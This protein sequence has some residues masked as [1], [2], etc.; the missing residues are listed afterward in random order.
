MGVDL[1]IYKQYSDDSFKGETAMKTRVEL[2]MLACD[3]LTNDELA[4]RGKAGFSKMITRKRMYA[5]SARVLKATRD[6]LADELAQS[7]K[8]IESLKAKLFQAESN[9]ASIE[10]LDGPVVDLSNAKDMIALAIAGGES[11]KQTK[12]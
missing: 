9:L 4:A 7:L 5:T 11:G 1:L 6:A 12:H 3:G 8:E 2:A 10:M